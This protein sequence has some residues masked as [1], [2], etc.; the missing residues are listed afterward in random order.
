MFLGY[1]HKIMTEREGKEMSLFKNL[2]IGITASRLNDS[3]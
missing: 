2:K 1:K 3:I